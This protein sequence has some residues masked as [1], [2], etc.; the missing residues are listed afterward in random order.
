MHGNLLE[1]P[2]ATLIFL[3]TLGISY[4][5]LS[6]NPR[7]FD[8]WILH[9]YA[10]AHEGR[11]F[12][13]VS[14]GF[15]HANYIHLL[16]NM[17][18]FWYFGFALER[19]LGSWRFAI[20]YFGSMVISAGVS[21]ARRKNSPSFR[22]LGASG[23]LSGVL[24]SFILFY[25]NTTLLAFFVLPIK[26]WL[27]AV[28]FVAISYYAAKN[29]YSYIDHEGHLWGALSGAGLTILLIPG[30]VRYFFSQLSF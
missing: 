3:A 13:L 4:Y 5:A 15:I 16:F 21:V 18:V 8:A 11:Y 10:V 20:I 12:Q 17:I 6:R 9:P 24:F 23:A 27:F 29:R 14:H 7:I 19:I 30:V 26:A 2:L 1:T 25:P 28:L 22:S